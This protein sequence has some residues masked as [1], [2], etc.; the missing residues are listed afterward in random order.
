METTNHIL[1]KYP[2]LS[3][4]KIRHLVVRSYPTGESSSLLG[5]VTE[6]EANVFDPDV[7]TTLLTV[8]W[9]S[10]RNGFLGESMPSV[11]GS[12]LF[13]TQDLSSGNH[14][15]SIVVTDEMGLS[16]EHQQKSLCWRTSQCKYQLSI[17][18]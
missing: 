12:V 15:I 11:D 17:F 9:Y 4:Q 8:E 6:L 5:V 1:S 16:C 7:S 2:F 14:Q 3:N 10:D 18:W 13:P